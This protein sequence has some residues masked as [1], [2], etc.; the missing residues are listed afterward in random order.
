LRLAKYQQYFLKVIS[1]HRYQRFAAKLDKYRRPIIKMQ[2]LVR[3][4][5][6]FRTYILLKNCAMLIQN[7]FRSYLKRKY[8][9]IKK[10]KDY[11]K[12]IFYD[13]HLKMKDLVQLGVPI[14]NIGKMKFYP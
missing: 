7:A 10:W 6:A 5:L 9:L 8:F 1:Y 14:K 4:K 13:E 11:R 2:A 3:G 12:Y